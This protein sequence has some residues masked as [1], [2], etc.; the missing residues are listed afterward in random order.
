MN[1]IELTS[2]TAKVHDPLLLSSN[3]LNQAAVQLF[4]LLL[5]VHNLSFFILVVLITGHSPQKVWLLAITPFKTTWVL[6]MC[7]NYSIH[8]CRQNSTYSGMKFKIDIS[9]PFCLQFPGGCA[10]QIK[11]REPAP[12]WSWNGAEIGHHQV[13]PVIKITALCQ[14]RMYRDLSVMTSKRSTPQRSRT[15]L[16]CV[17]FCVCGRQKPDDPQIEPYCWR[18]HYIM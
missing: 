8:W 13:F 9:V 18:H 16:F 7:N 14:M 11:T 4:W 12:S 2:P 10:P 1:Y 6:L 5:T 17:Y 15:T 3:C